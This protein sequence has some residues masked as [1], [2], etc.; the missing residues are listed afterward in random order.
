M[1]IN[2][3]KT[4]DLQS[5]IVRPVVSNEEFRFKELMQAHHYLGFLPKIG[6]TI[7]Y[8]GTLHDEWVAL[9]GFSSPALKCPFEI[10]GFVGVI[11]ISMI[12]CT[13]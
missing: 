6:E 8:I 11:V 7:W 4:P 2:P 5:I 13:W 12:V 9:L 10:N 3:S 1:Q